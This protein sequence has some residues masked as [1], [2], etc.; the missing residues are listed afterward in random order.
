MNAYQGVVVA[1]IVTV[2]CAK[3][4]AQG[5]AFV[6]RDTRKL[7]LDPAITI[8]KNI[9]PRRTD[10]EDL[11]EGAFCQIDCWLFQVM[12]VMDKK[13]ML[14]SVGK[15]VYWIE[16]YDT[17]TLASDDKIFI[18]DPVQF[19]GMKEYTSVVGDKRRVRHLVA[20][21]PEQLKAIR[22]E[23]REKKAEIFVIDGKEIKGVFVSYK[24]SFV[25]LED[26]DGNQ[27][28]YALKS[29]SDSAKARVRELS[30]AE[31]TPKK[32]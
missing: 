15:W 31:K 14:V 18:L 16:G 2:F 6:W 29:L 27:S 4:P 26:I 12:S 11:D 10:P 8:P 23:M 22:R 19:A 5:D 1:F 24:G 28:K 9:P 3:L 20:R 25:T 7:V 13:N 21:T 32:K 17:T 30:K